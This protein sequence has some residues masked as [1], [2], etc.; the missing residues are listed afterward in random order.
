MTRRDNARRRAILPIRWQ[1]AWRPRWGS[2]AFVT[3]DPPGQGS[4]LTF[5]FRKHLPLPTVAR[6]RAIP[7]KIGWSGDPAAKT[8]AVRAR[9]SIAGKTGATFIL[10]LI[11]RI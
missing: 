6:L 3:R 5:L 8:T 1:E 9:T 10:R 4:A 7:E 2:R 11:C